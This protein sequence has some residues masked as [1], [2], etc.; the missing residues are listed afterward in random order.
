MVGSG[1]REKTMEAKT[2]LKL[3]CKWGKKWNPNTSQ[4]QRKQERN[5]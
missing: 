2:R 3:M 1:S 4:R 5:G